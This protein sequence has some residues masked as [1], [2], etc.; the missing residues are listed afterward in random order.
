VVRQEVKQ[1]TGI[2]QIPLMLKTVV[3]SRE[4]GWGDVELERKGG[5][6]VRSSIANKEGGP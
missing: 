2:G 1:V 6:S 5:G 4:L 3:K